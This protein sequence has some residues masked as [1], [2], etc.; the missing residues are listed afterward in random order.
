MT[1]LICK[2]ETHRGTDLMPDLCL[3]RAVCPQ[4]SFL[5]TCLW[6]WTGCN[7]CTVQSAC[8]SSTFPSYLYDNIFSAG[9]SFLIFAKSWISTEFSIGQGSSDVQTQHSFSAA[10]MGGGRGGQEKQVM[11]DWRLKYFIN[12]CCS[13]CVVWWL[14]ENSGNPSFL[15]PTGIQDSPQVRHVMPLFLYFQG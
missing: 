8:R 9:A 1:A 6:W 2:V 10:I 12:Q 11:W 14:V 5:F 3:N 7:K 15:P 13:Q 4:S